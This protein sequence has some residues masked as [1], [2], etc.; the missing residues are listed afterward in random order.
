[1]T[2]H[3]K[4]PYYRDELAQPCPWVPPIEI[5][6]AKPPSME[7]EVW[8]E[9]IRRTKAENSRVVSERL[10]LQWS[11]FLALCDH[12]HINRDRPG[13]PRDLVLKL[14]DRHEP[15]FRSSLEYSE[16][17]ARYSVDPC[18]PE[19]DFALAWSLA[20]KH[21]PGL[22]FEI[23]EPRR[24]QL[25][26][27]ELASL[28]LIIERIRRHLL[29]SR[30]DDSDRKIVQILRDERRL[31]SIIRAPAAQ[32]L[33][34]WIKHQG[35]KRVDGSPGP[36]SDR[37]LREYLRLLKTAWKAYTEGTA[38]PLQIQFVEEVLP[39][40]FHPDADQAEAAETGQS[41]EQIARRI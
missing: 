16:L 12:F 14:A 1:M 33:S 28:F 38:N 31:K 22:R 9:A 11:R 40:L 25:S 19:A 10:S 2:K 24:T 26:T 17:F 34:A 39:L 30:Q 5:P 7:P 27:V 21:V 41:Q 32:T 3:R 23:P 8:E 20:S 4:R 18:M 6:S 15:W 37:A 13:W 29:N 35:N 36:V